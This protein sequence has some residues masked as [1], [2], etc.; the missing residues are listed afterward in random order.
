M[1]TTSKRRFL[2]ANFVVLV[3]V[4]YWVREHISLEELLGKLQGLPPEGLVV[5]LVLNVAV[6]G[7]Y[8]L[9]LSLLLTSQRIPALAVVI[10]GFGM[11]GMLPFRLGE[12]AKLAYARQLFGITPPRLIA[13]STAEKLMDLCALLLLGVVASLLLPPI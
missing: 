4:F 3:L 11:N 12:I 2:A 7:V 8:G 6:L 1:K 13:A 10:I 9:R 5:A